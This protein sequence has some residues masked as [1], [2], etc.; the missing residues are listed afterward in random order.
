VYSL[1]YASEASYG[2]SSWLVLSLSA[3]IMVDMPR[4]DSGLAAN[5]DRLISSE[6]RPEGIHHVVL[7]HTDDVAS[8]EAWENRF[9]QVLSALFTDQNAMAG[10]RLT[11]AR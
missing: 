4:Y 6:A 10:R 1:G 9:I 5:V 3:C 2:A 8:H 11:P 7:S